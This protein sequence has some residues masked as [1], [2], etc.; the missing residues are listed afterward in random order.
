MKGNSLMRVYFAP[1]GIGL[2]HVGRNAPIARKLL[3]KNTQVIFSTY[4]EGTDYIKQEKLPVVEAPPIGFQVKP[5]GTIDF[6]QTA[7]N[8]GPFISTFTLLKQVN[9]EIRF[10]TSFEPDVVV[11]D[12]RVSP[13]LAARCL[14]IPRICI[15]NQF[16]VIIP[17]RRRLLRLAR[18]ADFITLTLVG[19][20]WTSGNTVLIPDFPSPYTICSGNLNIPKSYRKR[21][22]LIGPILQ[23][24]PEELD[25]K[26]RL[27][28]KL[29]L[30]IGK[31]T[32]FVP[33]SGP[34]MERAF[35]TKIME[36][37]LLE[38]PEDY[39]VVMSLGEPSETRKQFHHQNVTVYSWV[40]NRFEYLKACDLVVAR[41]GHGTMTQCMCYGKPMILVPTP[42]HT[43]Q[44]S[45]AA[46]AMKLGLAKIVLQE[47]LSKEKLLKKVRQVFDEKIAERLA[48]FS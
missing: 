4:R 34:R 31:P 48:W 27:R 21:V 3:E 6:K 38:F 20:M 22:K 2:G 41:A 46:Q 16:Q 28:Q 12:S 30:P 47:D 36:K 42:S 35:L 25:S 37:I 8:P 40:P 1:C 15:L 45:N 17:R 9:A 29:G 7:V 24:R 32:I 19:K 39:E 5:D 44:L 11:S 10:M 14:R 33:I 23:K 13:L 43:E 18:F 26:E